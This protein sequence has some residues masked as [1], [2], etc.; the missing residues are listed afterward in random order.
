MD[1]IAI[2]YAV[3]TLYLVGI[4]AYGLTRSRREASA[5]RAFA[6]IFS[7]IERPL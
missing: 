4:L 6:A 7:D 1:P 3:M 2:V 5:E